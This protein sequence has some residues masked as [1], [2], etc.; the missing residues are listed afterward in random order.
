VLVLFIAGL[1]TISCDKSKE[2]ISP[3]SQMSYNDKTYDLSQG[4]GHSEE[5]ESEGIE[6]LN[7]FLLTSSF[8]VQLTNGRIESYT[9]TLTGLFLGIYMKRN[10]KGLDAGEYVCDSNGD[11]TPNTFYGG[12][13]LN[14]DPDGPSNFENNLE[15][16]RISV[17]RNNNIYEITFDC[18]DGEGKAVKGFYK[19]ELKNFD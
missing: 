14:A 1:S 10:T 16:G 9:G 19:G 8:K 6:E 2:A 18:T 11:G 7:L 12:V 4:I 15:V 17:K 5:Y 3:A 13:V